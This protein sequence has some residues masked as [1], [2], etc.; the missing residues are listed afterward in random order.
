MYRVAIFPGTFD[1]PHFGHLDVLE[2]ASQL[3]DK[4]CWLIGK[5]PKK[6]PMF[7]ADVRMLMMEGLASRFPNV[8]VG[9]F[10]KVLL[11][12][13]AHYRGAQYVVRS[14]RMAMDFE[15]EYQMTMVNRVLRPELDVVYFPARQ[16]HFHISSTAVRELLAAG[17]SVTK[18]VPPEVIKLTGQSY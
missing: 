4:V 9:E 16:D 8:T 3:F 15:Y 18:F 12:D 2:Q 14:L 6:Q 1:P 13:E 7:P 17:H 11:V 5:N 10:K